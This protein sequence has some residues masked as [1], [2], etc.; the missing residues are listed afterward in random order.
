LLAVYFHVSVAEL[1]GESVGPETASQ[2]A[3]PDFE[4]MGNAVTVLRE[5]LDVIGKPAEWVADPVLLETSYMVVEEF[6]GPVTRENVIDLTKRL[7]QKVREGGLDEQQ[8]QVQGAS[9]KAG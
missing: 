5:Y 2:P 9:A 1:T 7:G 8:R 3:R 6:G 4:K